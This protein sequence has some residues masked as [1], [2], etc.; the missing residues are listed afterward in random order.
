M[1]L[2][3]LSI[4]PEVF[5]E[6]WAHIRHFMPWVDSALVVTP[7]RLADRFEAADVVVLS[8]EKVTDMTSAQLAALDHQ[9]R[10]SALRRGLASRAE[11]DDVVLMSD[12]DSRPLKPVDRSLFVDPDGR[13][14][15]FYF[16]DL[17]AW[18]G[19]STPFDEGQHATAEILGYLGCERLAYASHQPQ[20]I[21][22]AH[23]REVW[24]TLGRLTDSTLVCEWGTYGNIARHLHPDDFAEPEPYRTLGWPMFPGEWPFWVRPAEYVFENFYPHLYEPGGLFAGLPTGLDP[25]RVERHSVEKILRWSSFGRRASALDFPDDVENPWIKRS[26]VRKATF[27]VLRRMRKAYDYLALED[28][29]RLSELSGTVSRMAEE[30]RHERNERP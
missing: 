9:S 24:K 6:S 1:Q 28:R 16:Y 8:D 23:L 3:T 2:V 21:R 19:R 27:A 7:E 18:P 5:R 15:L 29:A 13:H 20:I 25:E 17:A 10:N 30:T 22:T 12:D 4:R 14:R 26:P 11:V